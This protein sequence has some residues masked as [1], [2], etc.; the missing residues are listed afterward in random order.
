MRGEPTAAAFNDATFRMRYP[1]ILVSPETARARI[2]SILAHH[3]ETTR[4]YFWAVPPGLAI[5]RARV[6]LELFA[7]EVMP[8]FRLAA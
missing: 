4:L 3:P 1:W 8:G 5:P 6:S 7:R 2:A